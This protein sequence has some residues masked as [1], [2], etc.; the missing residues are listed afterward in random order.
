MER[1]GR[2]ALDPDEQPPPGARLLPNVV[3]RPALQEYLLP[4]ARVVCG[5][6]E[7]A[8]RR[9]LGPVYA[10]TG[11]AAAPLMR[12][13]SATLLPPAWG[14][15]EGAPDA[16]R[17]LD[18]PDAALEEWAR[19]LGDGDLLVE[20]AGLRSDLSA[21]FLSLG[22]RL[23]ETDRGL[24]QV[25]DSAAGKI[26]YQITRIEDAV[27]SKARATLYRRDPNL[28]SLRE[29]LL[30]RGRRQERSFT[31]WTPFLWEGMQPLDEL[32]AAVRGW[33]DR[34]ERGHAL[35]ALEDR[36]RA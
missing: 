20:L 32:G 35:F 8:Y 9:L 22:A 21:R 28:S 15:E 11:H 27:R 31:L 6:G 16:G 19:D 7:I 14:R 5:E 36:G 30:P 2:R 4:V 26:D 13:F 12:R 23:A 34:G 1:E 29:F 24:G 25:L 33:F 3:L 18:D 10:R 17:T